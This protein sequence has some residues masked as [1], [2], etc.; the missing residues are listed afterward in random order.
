MLSGSYTGTLAAIVRTLIR[1]IDDE[2][3]I[4]S[5]ERSTN[6]QRVYHWLCVPVCM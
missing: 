6:A 2:V 1:P 5:A 3:L 4:S